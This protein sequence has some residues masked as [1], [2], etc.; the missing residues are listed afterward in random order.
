MHLAPQTLTDRPRYALARRLAVT[1]LAVGLAG[2]ASG[3]YHPVS[4]A[5]AA[6][7]PSDLYSQSVEWFDCPDDQGECGT[8]QAPLD[9]SNPDGQRITV[10]F[11]VSRATDPTK[12]QGSL[13]V[14]PGGPGASGISSLSYLV[15]GLPEQV[16]ARYDIVGFDPRGVGLTMPVKCLEDQELGEFVEWLPRGDA[17]TAIPEAHV[18][19]D[20]F[21]QACLEQTGE[22]LG[23]IDTRSTARDMDVI[24]AAL[25]DEKLNY[26]G[27]SYGTFLGALYAQEFPERVGRMVLDGAVNPLKTSE[28]DSAEQMGA[29][30]QALEHYV[31]DCLDSTDCPLNGTVE[32][33]VDQIR[34]LI[35]GLVEQP[36]STSFD[37]RELSDAMALMGVLAALYSQDAWPMLTLSLDQALNQADGTAL[38]VLADT[39]YERD[40]ATGAFQTNMFEAFTAISCLDKPVDA[41]RQAIDAADQ[42]MLEASGTFGPYFRLGA[43]GCAEWPYPAAFQPQAIS[44]PTADPI[45]VVG[46]TGDPATPYA[47]AKALTEQLESAVLVTYEG[48]GHTSFGQGGCVDEPV[49]DYLVGGKVPAEGFTCGG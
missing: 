9:W 35:A 29:F 47:D 7:D 28:Q 15:A 4:R 27:Y 3:P 14:N 33:A 13:L 10:T 12:R 21:A 11:A 25:G 34:E 49:G 1:F 24:R 41:R 43:I 48:E 37:G 17:D 6:E 38:L 31:Q 32:Q 8:V 22:A 42:L 30:E 19:A 44:A 16:T 5:G 20:G 46:T 23:F 45:V 26:V 39:Y 2:W 18:L 36:L 40:S